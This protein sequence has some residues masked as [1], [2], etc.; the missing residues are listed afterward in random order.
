M[1]LGKYGPLVFVYCV[2]GVMAGGDV[3]LWVSVVW[4]GGVCV[5]GAGVGWAL[6]VGACVRV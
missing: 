1:G 4:G 6:R 2:C 5:H 3:G